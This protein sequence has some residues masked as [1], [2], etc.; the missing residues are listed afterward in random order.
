MEAISIRLSI[1]GSVYIIIWTNE[2]HKNFLIIYCSYMRI[3]TY[4]EVLSPI[5][6]IRVLKVKFVH[7]V[8][9][10]FLDERRSYTQKCLKLQNA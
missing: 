2:P 10:Y 3:N 6:L 7:F 1:N 4:T 8:A 9:K 5:R